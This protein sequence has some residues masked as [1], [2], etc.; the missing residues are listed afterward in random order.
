MELASGQ[1]FAI[2]GLLSDNTRA[3]ARNYP[4]FADLPILGALFQSDRFERRETELV[5]IVTPYLVRPVD[6]NQLRTPLDN[7][8]APPV[9]ARSPTPAAQSTRIVPLDPNNANQLGGKNTG[10][11]LD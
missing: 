9:A 1:S 11:I 2:A 7:Y 6:A 8:R 4:G 3:E 5:I 10:F